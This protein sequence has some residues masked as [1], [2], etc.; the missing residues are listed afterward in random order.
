MPPFGGE[1]K[2]SPPGVCGLSDEA[3]QD[4]AGHRAKVID[5][6]EGGFAP[7]LPR[8]PP[9]GQKRPNDFLKR[10]DSCI[11]VIRRRNFVFL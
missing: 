11:S 1:N 8:L 7:F 5:S 4:P 9:L 6:L 3:R 2:R 10:L